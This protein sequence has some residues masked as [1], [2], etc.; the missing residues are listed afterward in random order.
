MKSGILLH[1][2]T[3]EQGCSVAVSEGTDLLYVSSD[4]LPFQQTAR[5]PILIQEAL[6]HTGKTWTA[7]D[8][9][10]I[11]DGPGSYTALR[12]GASMAKAIC[13]THRI[14]L[15]AVPTMEMVYHSMTSL[16]EADGFY[17]PTL[18]ARRGRVFYAVY[19][20]QGVCIEGP[21]LDKI[22]S[23]IARIPGNLMA[24]AG[25]GLRQQPEAWTHFEKKVHQDFGLYSAA[26][27]IKP[28]I[29]AFQTGAYKDLENYV[30]NY[31]Q[32]PNITTPK[33]TTN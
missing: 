5:L 27:M 24:V 23:V 30:P 11:C 12:V 19:N 7:L 33:Q 4:H 14:P 3:V 31:I 9:V 29:L 26:H 6:T 21:A 10:A 20:I 18:D 2:E 17:V 16:S 15:I 25:T 22:E 13:Y 1:L 28:A 8:A 32:K